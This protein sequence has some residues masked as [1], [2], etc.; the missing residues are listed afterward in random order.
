MSQ[1][2]LITI[3]ISHYCEKARWALDR[4]GITYVESAHVP[5]AHLVFTKAAG[6]SS[7]PILVTPARTPMAVRS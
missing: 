1:H 6:G 2:R 5:L 3:A 4:A 7:T